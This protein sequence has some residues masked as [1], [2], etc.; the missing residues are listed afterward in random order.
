[1]LSSIEL[2]R[3]LRFLRL[4]EE[5]NTTKSTYIVPVDKD[6]D[7]ND[8]GDYEEGHNTS[9]FVKGLIN[10][11]VFDEFLYKL[12]KDLGNGHKLDKYKEVKNR[13]NETKANKK[14]FKN[15]IAKGLNFT[16]RLH[17]RAFNF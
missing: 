17:N 15:N 4:L 11:S 10:P 9:A 8:N 13:K 6:D 12:D 2:V 1:L 7:L 3:G 16:Q 14:E 5:T